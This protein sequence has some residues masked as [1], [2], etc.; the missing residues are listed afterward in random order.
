MVMAPLVLIH[1]LVIILAVRNG[2][3]GEEILQR[4]G[5]NFFWALFYLLFVFCA[6]VHAP[7]G[8][9]NVLNEWTTLRALIVDRISLL[10]A[11]ILLLTGLRAVIAV[12]F[13]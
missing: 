11:A 5:G 6:S 3:S 12:I 1:L 10:F 4:T 7:I 2:L 9:R 13:V 8:L